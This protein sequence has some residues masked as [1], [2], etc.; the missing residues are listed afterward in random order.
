MLLIRALFLFHNNN[1]NSHV[2]S[3]NGRWCIQT[4]HITID[5][6]VTVAEEKRWR[7]VA[8]WSSFGPADFGDVKMF[9]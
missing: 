2:H 7:V 9:C 6:S 5:K 1:S 3:T 8:A 4:L